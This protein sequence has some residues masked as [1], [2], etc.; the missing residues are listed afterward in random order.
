MWLVVWRRFISGIL[1]KRLLFNDNRVVNRVIQRSFSRRY[2]VTDTQT[3]WRHSISA[4]HEGEKIHSQASI[5]LNYNHR[6][7]SAALLTSLSNKCGSIGDYGA[8]VTWRWR[9]KPPEALGGCN[10][11]DVSVKWLRKCYYRMEIKPVYSDGG[12]LQ[13]VHNKCLR[14]ARELRPRIRLPQWDPVVTPVRNG[15]NA[16]VRVA[17]FQV[18]PRFQSR[19]T[20]LKGQ[21]QDLPA[22]LQHLSRVDSSTRPVAQHFCPTS[23]RLPTNTCLEFP[24][25]PLLL[26]YTLDKYLW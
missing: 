18:K 8:S 12:H 5:N 22:P 20:R 14:Q 21:V 23:P 13:Q 7:V 17:R 10:V 25:C 24:Y 19:R 4:G 3:Q 6:R 2:R 9:N 26:T 16:H 15:A 1:F 11:A